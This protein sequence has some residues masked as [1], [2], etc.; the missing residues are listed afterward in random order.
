MSYYEVIYET[1]AHS[2][3]SGD[4]KEVLKGL[5][6]QHRRAVNGEPGG[7]AGQPAERVKTV[8]KYDKHPNDFSDNLTAEVA[9]KELTELVKANADENGV[10][11]SG[12]L[13]SAARS[14]NSPVDHAALEKSRHASMFKAKEVAT[15][16]SKGWE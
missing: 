9:T 12:V 4:E 10:V 3:V 8:L 11:G 2:V 14:L 15:L 13:A 1:G 16:D 6:E 5:K 7:P